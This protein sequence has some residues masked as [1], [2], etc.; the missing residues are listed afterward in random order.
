MHKLEYP[1][2]ITTGGYEVISS[3]IVHITEPEI[4]FQLANIVV[5]Y[6]FMSD[7]G[8]GRFQGEI[9]DNELVINLFN[10]TAVLG[11]G[12]LEPVE[13]GTLGGRKLFATWYVN[14]VENNIRQFIYTFMLLEV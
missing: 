7:S 4:K 9:V 13:I 14:T 2:K 3:G 10:S 6:R 8:G 5:K 1:I 11:D 12:K